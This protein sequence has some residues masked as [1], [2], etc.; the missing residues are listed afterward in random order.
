MKS[1]DQILARLTK[2]VTR[3]KNAYVLEKTRKQPC[4]CIYNIEDQPRDL[5]STS[6]E[7]KLAPRTSVSLLV[8]QQPSP[9]R[10]CG[11]ADGKWNGDICDKEEIA[12][13]CKYF[14]PVIS[15]EVAS[16]EFEDKLMDDQYILATYPDVAALQWAV[17]DRAYK[18]KIPV[19]KRFLSWLVGG[20]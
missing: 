3:H 7:H 4:N 6:V 11:Y 14:V 18:V 16:A 19:W 8:I 17:D 1:K 12:Q 9:V 5:L 13:A 2:L 10:I 15:K 20:W